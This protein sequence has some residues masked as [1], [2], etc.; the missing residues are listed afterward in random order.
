[1]HAA[2]QELGLTCCVQEEEEEEEGEGQGEGE[3]GGEEEEEEEEAGA[4][5]EGGGGS[6]K[7]DSRGCE[8][9]RSKPM[10]DDYYEVLGVDATGT[11][12]EIK[13]AYRKAALKH[14]PDKNPGMCL[15]YVVCVYVSILSIYVVCV[16]HPDKNAGMFLE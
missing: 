16:Y 5:G 7:K 8:T 4:R 10:S 12:D 9:D 6:K 11:A 2:G 14:H 1:M 3:G 13:K 15:S